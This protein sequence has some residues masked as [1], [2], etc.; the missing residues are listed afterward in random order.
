MSSD[1]TESVSTLDS[2]PVISPR[3]NLRRARPQVSHLNRIPHELLLERLASA[4]EPR[5]HRAFRD[6]E[7]LRHLV[8]AEPV[9]IAQHDRCSIVLRER[10]D[11]AVISSSRN[12]S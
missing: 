6:E 9:H 5:L 12:E 10:L 4:K 2:L 7:D 11:R 3:R 1:L 8:V